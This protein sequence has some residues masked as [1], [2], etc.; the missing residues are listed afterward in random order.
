MRWLK[1][2]RYTVQT[3]G[4]LVLGELLFVGVFRCP[5]VVPFIACPICPLLQCP[6]KYLQPYLVWVLVGT[7]LLAGRV[8]CGWLCPLGFVQD[9]LAKA[10]R[11]KG[12]AK[13]SGNKLDAVLKWLKYPL[14]ALV[15]VLIFS[16]LGMVTVPI[17]TGSNFSL[18]SVKLTFLFASGGYKVRLGLAVL[19]LVGA[20][21]LSRLWCRYL[22]PLGAL[23]GLA[24][25][26]SLW[27][28]RIDRERCV[29]CGKYPRECPL[30]TKPGMVDCTLCGD[31]LNGCPRK[32]IHFEPR[33]KG[34]SS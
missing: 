28:L 29:G 9:L 16:G 31:C 21:F 34:K 27:R 14:L 11:L 3:L 13:N 1:W 2:L 26:V 18:E 8:F 30:S 7:G 24:N 5:F 23:L 33:L 22:C 10:S 6:G 15:L 19:A 20:L 25:K 17:H 4:L 32:A 12:Q